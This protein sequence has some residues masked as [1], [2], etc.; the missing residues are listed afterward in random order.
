VAYDLRNDYYIALQRLPF[1]FYDRS[2]TGDLMSRA[3]GDIAE[4]ERFAGIGLLDLISV[5]L[6]IGGVVAAMFLVSWQ[7]SLLTLGPV[8]ALVGLGLRF[9]MVVRP[10]F[11]ADSGTA[12]HALHGDAG[13]HD[14][15]WGGQGV[16]T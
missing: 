15:D 3:T 9:G 13:E 6:L 12:W 10:M 5:V 7:L 14:W 11:S 16:C 8:L 1:S 2:H 4:T